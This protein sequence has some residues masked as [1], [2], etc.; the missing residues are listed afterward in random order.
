MTV[1]TCRPQP[2]HVDFSVCASAN[3][4][5]VEWGIGRTAGIAGCAFAH[6]V[7]EAK[8][9]TGDCGTGFLV[10]QLVCTLVG[11][12]DVVWLMPTVR[13]MASDELLIYEG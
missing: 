1:G 7:P 3:K 10:V 5:W 9:E 8:Q 12:F 4:V 13:A 2:H 6:F 11:Y